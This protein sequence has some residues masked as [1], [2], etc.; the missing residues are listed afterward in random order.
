[1]TRVYYDDNFGAY[2]IGPEDDPDEIREF[3][4]R[5]QDESVEKTCEGCRRLVRIRP[6][7]GYCNSCATILERGGDPHCD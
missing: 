7:Y 1:M 5:M 6:S 4:E 3:Y 2:E